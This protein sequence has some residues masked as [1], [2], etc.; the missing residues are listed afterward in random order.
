MGGYGVGFSSGQGCR[1]SWDYVGL[2]PVYSGGEQNHESAVGLEEVAVARRVISKPLVA[3]GG[4]NR[5]NA[6]AVIE[7]GADS[8][9]VRGDLMQN[10]PAGSGG[11]SK[12]FGVKSFHP[13][14]CESGDSATQVPKEDCEPVRN[15]PERQE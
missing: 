9:A 14:R 10:P 13:I 15:C 5:T 11:I 8:V 1:L 3:F 6:R 2:G 4:V 7:A 12:H